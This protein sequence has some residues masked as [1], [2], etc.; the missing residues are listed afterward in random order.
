MDVWLNFA[1]TSSNI[2]GNC[3]TF[4]V[5]PFP[6]MCVDNDADFRRCPN[7]QSCVRRR[8][9]CDKEI[10]CPYSDEN[11]SEE[12]HCKFSHL[13]GGAFNNVP[14]T[15]LGVF[16]FVVFITIS[17]LIFKFNWDKSEGRQ[18]ALR[19]EQEKIEALFRV[20]KKK[21]TK[22]ES[23]ESSS[24]MSETSTTQVEFKLFSNKF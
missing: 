15:F 7:S 6:K 16:F 13:R 5:T 23:I 12:D 1:A 22:K 17:L 9:F 21:K 8:L 10:N 3:L 24:S 18:R 19:M 4:I 14:V 11:S 20:K 2:D